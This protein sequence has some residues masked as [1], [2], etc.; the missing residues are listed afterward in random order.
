MTSHVDHK[1]GGSLA[2]FMWQVHRAL[3]FVL[4]NRTSAALEASDDIVSFNDAN[5]LTASIQAKHSFTN[6]TLTTASVEFWKTI[7]VWSE[8]PARTQWTPET[9]LTLLTT[10]KVAAGS[11]IEPFAETSAALKAP[12][13][14]DICGLIENL[15]QVAKARKNERLKPCYEAWE[16]LTDAQRQDMVRR[17]RVCD[18]Q[19]RLTD[20]TSEIEH[21]VR[22]LYVRPERVVAFRQELIG[23][24]V[25]HVLD[26]LR[27]GGC[28]IEHD[29][30]GGKIAE[31]HDKLRPAPLISR[32][33]TGPFPELSEEVAKDPAYIRQLA[34][35]NATD[36]DLLA[37]VRNYHRASAERYGWRQAGLL[38]DA[39]LDALDADLENQWSMVRRKCLRGGG[40]PVEKGW[41]IHNESLQQCRG[42]IRSEQL[43]SH[44]NYGSLYILSDAM[45][46]GWHPNFENEL[47]KTKA[48]VA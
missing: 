2:G 4:D 30:V 27:V 20:A 18:A 6:S 47:K 13:D 38:G 17:I 36:E 14:K 15:G 28:T 48:R 22:R 35:L 3:I 5:E 8:Y 24:F 39:E 12:T 31:I 26:Q 43:P 23:W 41:Q 7:R 16:S 25:S 9:K 29:L 21:R 33:N 10:S 19:L 44:V 37:A 32:Y 11:T 1:A 34:I 45:I 40:D 46:V 42:L